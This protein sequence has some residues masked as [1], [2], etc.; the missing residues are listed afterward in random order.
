MN[1][2]LGS[3][4]AAV[5]MRFGVH[6]TVVTAANL[7]LALIA[8]V[9]VIARA[10]QLHPGW[11]PGVLAM[12][13]WQLAFIFDCADGQVARATGKTSSFGAR[14]DTLVDFFVH[15]IVICALASVI[16]AQTNL[17]G[18]VIVGLG[19]FWPVNLLICALARAD[20][21]IGHSFT[22]REGI[23]AVIKLGR[24]TGFV[25]LVIGVWLTAHPQTI[26]VPAVAFAAFNATFLLASIGREA[27]LSMR[28][29][30]EPGRSEKEVRP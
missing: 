25:L 19:I 2:P 26:V 28:Q 17:P 23:A 14:V 7:G 24:D 10:E 5:A 3:W 9:I 12:L 22:G 13:L 16:A 15:A 21:N 4:V 11:V 30:T 27:Y 6:P 1:D 8:G 18:A 29:P 20:G